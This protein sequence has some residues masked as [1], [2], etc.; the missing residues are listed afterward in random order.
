MHGRTMKRHR[1]LDD[2]AMACG[3]ALTM[4]SLGL[5]A[6][7]PAAQ[8]EITLHVPY[9][10]NGPQEIQSSERATRSYRAIAARSTPPITDTM[11]AMVEAALWTGAD[12]RVTRTRRADPSALL[13]LPDST[14]KE[15]RQALPDLILAGDDVLRTS[16]AAA[17]NT[18]ARR[19]PMVVEPIAEMPY[20]LVCITARC[21]GVA[22]TAPGD[23][24]LS[25]L[26]LRSIGTVGELGGS[27]VAG[28]QWIA[29]TR[30]EPL[31][32]PYA[33]GNGI[34]GDLVA[35]RIEAAFLA[36][37]LALRHLGHEKLHALGIT[38]ARRLEALP[39]LPTLAEAGTP[40]VFESWFAI[41]ASAH[42]PAAM[43]RRVQAALRAYRTEE[44]TRAEFHRIGLR[45]SA[46]TPAQLDIRIES[47]RARLRTFTP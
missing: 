37:P 26:R 8:A 39:D 11:A 13:T 22:A 24:R 40:L 47:E 33:G 30:T 12:L 35:E 15:A 4:S 3:L 32:V 27:T 43:S 20:V 19:L 10:V 1:R 21:G 31:L 23:R 36:L 29:L 2:V 28:R 6:A 14:P 38:T 7:Q 44:A 46:A 5:H 9:P 41:F 16:L 17:T 25:S 18:G 34:V 42:L 45:P